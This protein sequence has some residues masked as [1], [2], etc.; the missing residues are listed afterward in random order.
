M[1]K[2]SK[3]IHLKEF[4]LNSHEQPHGSLG[5]CHGVF[6]LLHIGHIK[7][8][9]EAKSLCD[10]LIVSLTPDE[11]VN[12][13]PGRPVFSAA[14]RA[15]AI[16][17]LDCVDC[18]II[19]LWPTAID[20]I[21]LLKPDF[22][23]KGPDYKIL[24]DDVTGKIFEEKDAIES[25]GGKLVFT[26]GE[27]HS[28]SHL[29]NDMKKNSYTS[30]V[31]EWWDSGRKKINFKE[32]ISSFKAIEKLK[33]CVI[34]ENITDVYSSYRP[35]GRSSKGASLVFEKGPSE[36]YDGGVLAV[37]K[38]LLSLHHDVTV[39]TNKVTTDINYGLNIKDLNVGNE[40]VK[41]RVLDGHTFEKVIEFYNN[42]FEVPWDKK[43][44][45]RFVKLIGE[46]KY[47]MVLCFDFGHGFFNNTII[48]N[49]ESLDSFLVL[50]VQTN[51]G[52]R[53]YNFPTKWT[54]A[55]LLSI[56]AEEL[57]LSLQDK[58]S[59]LENKVEKLRKNNTFDKIVVTRGSSGNVIFDREFQVVT[60]AF[61]DNVK[62]RV[63]AGD[64][65]LASIAGHFFQNA[66]NLNSIGL[67]GNIAGAQSLKH[68]ANKEVLNKVD[69][70]KSIEHILK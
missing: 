14:L 19:N 57:S 64:T 56:T 15:E 11:F 37:A 17:A 50:N 9:Q 67:I 29:I 8:F 44:E 62:D 41:E 23:I 63:G 33:V 58:S 7:Y 34:G 18:V 10:F 31:L 2:N 66:L 69:L 1:E 6:D 12:K 13:G 28:S 49:V 55:D 43:A 20:T 51:A 25:V 27:I 53:G 42:K 32:I 5:H 48:K 36:F 46:E 24:E 3:I 26:S 30:D 39:I 61:A 52:N 35:L 59:C 68:Q 16:A 65:F 21:K 22:Y 54:R 60:P 38:N 47:D 4:N 40:I 70:L 45:D